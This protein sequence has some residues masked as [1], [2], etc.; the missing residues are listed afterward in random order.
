MKDSAAYR[1]YLREEL[2]AAMRIHDGLMGDDLKNALSAVDG[3][4]RIRERVDRF[5]KSSGYAAGCADYIPECKGVCCRWHYPDKLN[6]R[7]MF[8]AVCTA[9]RETVERLRQHL[10]IAKGPHQ[11]PV[12]KPDGCALPFESRPLVC[13]NAYPCLAGQKYHDFLQSME[14]EI[15]VRFAELREVL[16]KY[17]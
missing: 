1:E 9:G 6:R 17:F 4:S 3:I 7:D 2:E 5:A 8:V 13:S 14:E 16:D 10:A 11:C 15:Q 12:L